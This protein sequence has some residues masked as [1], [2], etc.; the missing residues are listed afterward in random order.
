MCL[1]AGAIVIYNVV[2][3]LRN[4]RTF[5]LPGRLQPI[6][7]TVIIFLVLVACVFLR[8]PESTFIYFQF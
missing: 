4:H 3:V 8:G 5:R 7:L 2:I 6:A 1:L